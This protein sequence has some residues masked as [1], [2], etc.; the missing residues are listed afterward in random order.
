MKATAMMNDLRRMI[1]AHCEDLSVVIQGPI[2]G[3]TKHES[4]FFAEEPKGDRISDGMEIV[5]RL[6][7]Y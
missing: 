3:A 1:E 7:P 6:W 4:F 2:D 5:L